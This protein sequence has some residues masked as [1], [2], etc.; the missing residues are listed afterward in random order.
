MNHQANHRTLIV[1][2]GCIGLCLA[3]ELS[4][5]GVD[6]TVVDRDRI[7]KGTSWAAAGIL[8]AA[9]YET[10]TDPIDRLRGYSHELFQDWTGQLQQ[11][12]GIDTG[13]RRCGGWFLADTPGEQAAM[14]GMTHYWRELQIQCERIDN[15]DVARR[16]PALADW[17]TR[18]P[19]VAAWWTPDECQ[20]RCPDYL[21]A[22]AA[23]CEKQNVQL[24]PRTNIHDLRSDGTTVQVSTE[25]ESNASTLEAD[26]VVICSGAWSGLAAPSLK[27]DRSI[28]PIRGQILLLKSAQPLLSGVV[29]VGNRYLVVRDDG[30]TL[31]GSCE[32]EVGH[33]LGTTAEMLST[34]RDFALNLCPQLSDAAEVQSWSGLRPMTFDGFPMLGRVPETTN[35]YVA[36]G[37]Y[38]SGVH[39][40]PATA[41]IMA[42]LMTGETPQVDISHFGVGKQ[43]SGSAT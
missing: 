26:S 30:H 39:L 20:I 12:T 27:L 42:D 2:G 25:N 14:I 43:Q 38:R 23:A 34:L 13:F 32:E 33:Q 19:N 16:E 1:G 7:G 22:L 40:S 28:V 3:W 37:H 29:N 18:N 11:A 31:V 8:P 17:L 6:V 9:K 36:S 21:A 4:H 41:K 5:R 35:V 24:L 10:A 15:A